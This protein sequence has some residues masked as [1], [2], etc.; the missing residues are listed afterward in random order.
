MGPRKKAAV[1]DPA[2][3]GEVAVKDPAVECEVLG[4]SAPQAKPLKKRPA[5]KAAVSA[6]VS[7]KT[8]LEQKQEKDA[9]PDAAGER[10]ATSTALAAATL[11][12]AVDGEPDSRAYSK[13]QKYVFD[14][15]FGD[16]DAKIQTEW[17]DLTDPLQKQP[18]KQA[19]K[20]QIVNMCVPRHVEYKGGSLVMKSATMER[21]MKVTK[22]SSDEIAECG[23]S[24]TEMKAKMG[25][26]FDEGL[27]SGDI[28]EENSFFYTKTHKKTQGKL[29]EEVDEL[30]KTMFV[31]DD[32]TF[33]GFAAELHGKMLDWANY[34]LQEGGP[35]SSDSAGSSE[36]SAPQVADDELMMRLQE[37]FDAT[38][39]LTHQ[40]KKAGQE[41]MQVTTITDE[42]MQMVKRGSVSSSISSSSK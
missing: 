2:I 32:D 5:P 37:S 41:I 35:K 7:L 30:N 42:G 29:Y 13:Q 23:L 36:R 34:A 24:R 22:S 15:F 1:K 26:Y 9:Q 12:D 39:R 38:T 31:P 17:R 11:V 4:D 3:E 8:F 19:R 33:L 40:V 16:L 14:K 18:N 27:A 6:A 10:A 28:W 21:I 25:V 20:N